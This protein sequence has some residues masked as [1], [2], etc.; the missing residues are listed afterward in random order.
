MVSFSRHNAVQEAAAAARTVGRP[1]NRLVERAMKF[2]TAAIA[3][4]PISAMQSSGLITLPRDFAHLFAV[5]AEDHA[6]AGAFLVAVG[7]GHRPMS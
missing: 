5:L 4:A 7:A 2:R 6:V 1:W 3:S